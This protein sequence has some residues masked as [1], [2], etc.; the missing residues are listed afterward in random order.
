[1]ILVILNKSKKKKSRININILFFK[2]I[3]INMFKI[4][5]R[6]YALPAIHAFTNSIE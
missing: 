2:S 5:S 3:E 1:M 4:K 6:R